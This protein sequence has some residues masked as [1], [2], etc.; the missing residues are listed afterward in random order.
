M[1]RCFAI[2]K[3]LIN[4]KRRQTFILAANSGAGCIAE[5]VVQGMRDKQ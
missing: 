4:E 5:F 2:Q 1:L 3:K